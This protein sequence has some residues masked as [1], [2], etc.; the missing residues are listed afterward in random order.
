MKPLKDVLSPIEF[1]G[2][3]FKA[4]Y[5]MPLV[6]VDE[7]PDGVLMVMEGK[8]FK[9]PDG[10]INKNKVYLMG[11]STLQTKRQS[12]FESFI[13]ILIGYGVAVV[14]QI[15]IYPFFDFHPP[16]EENLWIA[17]LFTVISFIRSYFVRRLFNWWHH[18]R[19][20]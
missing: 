18:L 10:T 2:L 14:S 17:G 20:G 6:S 4:K 11:E 19:E 13:N 1:M 15:L 7:M 12:L 8:P 9:R 5:P 16:L 3:K